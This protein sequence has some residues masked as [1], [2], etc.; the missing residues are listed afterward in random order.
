M[1]QSTHQMAIKGK[2]QTA[3]A[4]KSV[5]N[6]ASTT[7]ASIRSI[8]GGAIAAAGAYLSVRSFANGAKELGK[9]SDLAMKSGT[10]VEFL[11]S[12]ATAFQVAGLDVS[13][14]SL[15]KSMQYMQKTVGD[16]PFDEVL[17]QIADIPD[18]AERAQAVVKTFGRSGMELMPLVNG[19]KEAIEKFETL[20]KVM[21]SVSSSAAAAGDEAADAIKIFGDGAQ[22]I[23]LKVVGKICSL[24]GEQF[25]GGVRA[26][27]L[28]AIN[29][30]ETFFKKSWAWLQKWATYLGAVGG[31]LANVFETG[32]DTAWKVFQDQ[33][34]EASQTYEKAVA[35]AEEAREEYKATL[36]KLDVDTLANAYGGNKGAAAAAGAAGGGASPRTSNA[37]VLGG[38]NEA[39]RLAILGPQYQN[40]M[41]KQTAA[42]EKI[43]KNTEKTA[44]NTEGDAAESPPVANF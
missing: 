7:A 16:A 12:A 30:V 43:A 14:E 38:S 44:E 20:R 11:T 25:P 17:K 35:A 42:L 36:A 32:H 31:Y 40:E 5:Q 33:I 23:M 29:W 37:L 15:A 22:N 8:M 2:D 4:F 27:A 24:W 19:G 39:M 28:N 6:R 1:S 34:E 9:L 13:A 26:G 21:P 41:K 18:A 10:S 3:A